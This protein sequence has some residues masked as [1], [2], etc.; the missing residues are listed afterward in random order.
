MLLYF[1]ILDQVVECGTMMGY[2]RMRMTAR[3]KQIP[4]H[5]EL[6]T[7]M[8]NHFGWESE[9]LTNLSLKLVVN[10]QKNYQ[11]YKMFR[12]PCRCI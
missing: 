6:I 5:L 1:K 10:W 9:V 7:E 4:E 2:I 8:G 12:H 11:I 3:G